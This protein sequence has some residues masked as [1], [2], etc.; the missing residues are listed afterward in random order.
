MGLIGNQT[1]REACERQR[2][3]HTADIHLEVLDA[4][5]GDVTRG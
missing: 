3:L 5:G 2:N 4:Q 1:V